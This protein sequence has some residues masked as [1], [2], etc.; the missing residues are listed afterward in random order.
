MRESF[1]QVDPKEYPKFWEAIPEDR[2]GHFDPP[3][4]ETPT[5]QPGVVDRLVAN[6]ARR[7][8]FGKA[9]GMALPQVGLA[10]ALE[11]TGIPGVREFGYA[12]LDAM[13]GG[14]G[15]VKPQPS[16]EPDQHFL[17]S[18]GGGLLGALSVYGPLGA[19]RGALVVPAS[20]RAKNTFEAA[21]S[22]ITNPKVRKFGTDLALWRGGGEAAKIAQEEGGFR[23]EPLPASLGRVAG[24]AATGYGEALLPGM[25]ALSRTGRAAMAGGYNAALAGVQGG[26]HNALRPNDVEAI[27]VPGAMALNAAF[28]GLVGGLVPLHPTERAALE[29]IKRGGATKVPTAPPRPPTAPAAVEPSTRVPPSVDQLR[30]VL[31]EVNQDAPLQ[32]LPRSD[33][34]SQVVDPFSTPLIAEVNGRPL[35]VTAIVH[36]PTLK[37]RLG[38]RVGQSKRPVAVA[39]DETDGSVVHLTSDE[40]NSA[41]RWIR[42][43]DQSIEIPN[44]PAFEVLGN[45]FDRADELP[46]QKV[47]GKVGDRYVAIDL[48]TRQFHT[49]SPGESNRIRQL[50]E[51]KRSTSVN[52][53]EFSELFADT[54]E[55]RETAAREVQRAQARLAQLPGK[56]SAPF[57]AGDPIPFTPRPAEES[58]NRLLGS[59]EALERARAALESVGARVIPRDDRPLKIAPSREGR[60]RVVTAEGQV[61]SSVKN[62]R[63]K[64]VLDPALANVEE[65][66]VIIARRGPEGRVIRQEVPESTYAQMEKDFYI[67]TQAIKIPGEAK[68][69]PLDASVPI[70]K[71]QGD[72]PSHWVIGKVHQTDEVMIYDALDN[73]TSLVPKEAVP[74]YLRLELLTQKSTEL[75]Q[76]FRKFFK[77][78]NQPED[79]PPTLGGGRGRQ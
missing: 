7:S 4:W 56:G 68:V 72:T 67:G 10:Q 14:A 8:T 47:M 28:G 9:M 74:E 18:L 78:L 76:G 41:K 11:D 51:L 43:E 54:A 53:A 21:K 34:G 40:L 23:D 49:L 55:G 65:P 71:P 58:I 63:S 31:E 36:D 42:V 33:I 79:A 66:V 3:S 37:A 24:A 27:D 16:T 19:A 2:R 39:V 44:N 73:T 60:S 1:P 64:A 26:V 5:E 35:R 17:A 52:K 15:A 30:K 75:S 22:I 77:L 48:R 70:F 38:P 57:P 6:R 13:A 59:S 62:P 69:I 61:I 25:P 20:T 32:V 29:A 50:E 12:A 46:H 45:M